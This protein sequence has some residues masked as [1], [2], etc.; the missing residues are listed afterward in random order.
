MTIKKEEPKAN[1]SYCI[2]DRCI[3]RLRLLD[4]S[5]GKRVIRF[6]AIFLDFG[7]YF[8][9]TKAETKQVLQELADQGLISIYAFHGVKLRE[10]EK[11][12]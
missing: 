10:V 1:K 7:G 12:D 2:W 3:D 5:R 9:M 6:P 4:R 11:N 8:H